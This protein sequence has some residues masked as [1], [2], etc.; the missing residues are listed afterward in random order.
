M[1]LPD[2]FG[3]TTPM[4]SPRRTRRVDA[5]E[6]HAP[7]ARRAEALRVEHDVAGARGRG[8]AER[9][10][11][12]G[13]PDVLGALEA[14]ELVEHLAPALRLLRLLPGDVLADEVL[15]L[16]DEGLLPLG[17]RALAREVLLAGDGVVG[18]ARR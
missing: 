9:D 10:A 14:I 1:V 16:G 2:P 8:E 15:G 12:R 5:R 17:E 3:P 13:G 4:R 6:E 11:L 7:A 18:V